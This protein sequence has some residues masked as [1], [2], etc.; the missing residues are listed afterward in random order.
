M[1]GACILRVMGYGYKAWL[2]TVLWCVRYPL[3]EPV[4]N[5]LAVFFR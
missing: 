5:Y 1:E 3:M 4:K 2:V